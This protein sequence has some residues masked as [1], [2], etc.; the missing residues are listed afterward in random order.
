M[1][2][3][4]CLHLHRL[5][6]P[7]NGPAIRGVC[8]DCGHVRMY[9]ASP[10]DVKPKSFNNKSIVA[11]P[12]E[13]LAVYGPE[14]RKSK[15]KAPKVRAPL[16]RPEAKVRPVRQQRALTDNQR[17]TL[18]YVQARP[19]STAPQIAEAFTLDPTTGWLRCG[20]VG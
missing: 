15:P 6:D 17:L 18:E 4:T 5:L 14:P 19:R 2:T 13:Y 8:A 10:E 11:R 7:P 20:R 12:V 1:T 16:K 9:P 3:E